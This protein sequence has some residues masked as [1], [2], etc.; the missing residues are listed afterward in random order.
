MEQITRLDFRL[1]RN[2]LPT[3]YVSNGIKIPIYLPKTYQIIS[4]PFDY[5]ICRDWIKEVVFHGKWE[6]D[7]KEIP[8]RIWIRKDL[9]IISLDI[10]RG[11]DHIK[12]SLEKEKMRIEGKNYKILVMKKDEENPIAK[13]L[14]IEGK[15]EKILIL[16]EIPGYKDFLGFRLEDKFEGYLYSSNVK[17]DNIYF[18][19][20]KNILIIERNFIS[21]VKLLRE[22]ENYI[23][24]RRAEFPK[25]KMVE[26]YK[27]KDIN[28]A[29]E[30]LR[31]KYSRFF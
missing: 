31:R 18:I 22:I 20:G 11:E 27:M 17:D 6:L 29:I 16:G 8:E 19:D 24:I 1:E 12:I 30:F 5:W 4:L 21:E 15:T 26:V 28:D 10:L 25:R 2:V 23:G 13:A 3:R 9:N 14:K 7:G